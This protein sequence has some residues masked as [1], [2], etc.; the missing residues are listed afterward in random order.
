MM[1]HLSA[2][3]SKL[4]ES[5]IAA[6]LSTLM[7][8]VPHN[9]VNQL[10]H[11]PPQQMPTLPAVEERT[12]RELFGIA[13]Q[14]GKT[15]HSHNRIPS[16]NPNTILNSSSHGNSTSSDLISRPDKVLQIM[17]NWNIKFNGGIN[18]LSVGNFIYRVEALTAQTLQGNYDI[19]CGN[20]SSLF[21]GKASD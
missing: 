21:E 14:S 9:N 17:S 2:H 3:L 15:N 8:T 7:S 20:V 10:P 18:G 6:S 19:L 1:I 16:G 12:F 11:T 4:I 13:L 5:N